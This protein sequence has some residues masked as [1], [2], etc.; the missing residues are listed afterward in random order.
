MLTHND[1][2]IRQK[3]ADKARHDHDE[4]PDNLENGREIGDNDADE[5]K[6]DPQ[7]AK[8]ILANNRKQSAR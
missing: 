1:A 7:R 5:V 4:R 3:K 8:R 2:A 6:E